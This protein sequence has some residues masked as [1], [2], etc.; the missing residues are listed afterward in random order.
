MIIYL[1]E[2]GTCESRLEE[3]FRKDILKNHTGKEGKSQ[4]KV[5]YFIP[6]PRYPKSSQGE[7]LVV[8]AKPS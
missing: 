3:Y 6:S 4:V 8:P 1:C 5:E 2:C 7:I